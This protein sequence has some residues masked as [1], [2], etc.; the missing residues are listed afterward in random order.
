VNSPDNVLH[1]VLA[2]GMLGLGVALG[3]KASSDT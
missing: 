1:L 2:L 3:G